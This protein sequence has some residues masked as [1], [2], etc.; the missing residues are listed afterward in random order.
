MQCKH[1]IDFSDYNITEEMRNLIQ[2]RQA[3][4]PGRIL[5]NLW[6]M[7][8]DT[9]SEKTGWSLEKCASILREETTIT[10]DDANVLAKA[11]DTTSD[12][13]INLQNKHL[14]SK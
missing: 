1:G 12:V 3:A 10:I 5:R 9:L 2:Q 11:F 4:H 13:W 14:A 8:D 7:A 6:E